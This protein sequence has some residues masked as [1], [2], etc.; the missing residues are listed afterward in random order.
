MSRLLGSR[1]GCVGVEVGC[2]EGRD[3]S[4][5][6]LSVRGNVVSRG[7]DRLEL[8]PW[9]EGGPISSELDRMK[10]VTLG[11]DDQGGAR[12]AFEFFG[13]TV[14]GRAGH[15]LETDRARAGAGA[16]ELAGERA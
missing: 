5:H 9:N 1:G 6:C 8:G 14:W 4:S 12:D 13:L 3:S 15:L 2:D 16:L 10:R 7:D 11:A